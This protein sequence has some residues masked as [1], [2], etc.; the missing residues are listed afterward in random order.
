[1]CPVLRR[2]SPPWYLRVHRC[3]RRS[4]NCCR[5]LSQ[6]DSCLSC[7]SPHFLPCSAKSTVASAAAQDINPALKVRALQ[8]RVSPDTE[9]VFDDTFWANLD[10]VV[11]ALDNVNARLYVDSRCVYFCKPLLESGTLGPKCNTQM[12][13]PRMTENYGRKSPSVCNTFASLDS[14]PQG[15]ARQAI[16]CSATA[17]LGLV[18]DALTGHLMGL[19]HERESLHHYVVIE[20]SRV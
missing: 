13:I 9:D 11:N 4:R 19:H 5:Y 14:P 3:A 6:C 16:Q 2:P 12:V 1:M 20:I 18:L 15:H 17:P 10:V 7:K 8:N